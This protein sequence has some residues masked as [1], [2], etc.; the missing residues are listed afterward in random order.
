MTRR[1]LP[2][3]L[4]YYSESSMIAK[5]PGGSALGNLENMHIR[6][7]SGTVGDQR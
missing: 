4:L 3:T 6:N 1:S 7:I 5:N 2:S